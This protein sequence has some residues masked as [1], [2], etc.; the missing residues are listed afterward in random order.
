MASR[1]NECQATQFLHH[2]LLSISPIRSCAHLSSRASPVVTLMRSSEAEC[3]QIADFICSKLRA[4][5]DPS[6]HPTWTSTTRTR[7]MEW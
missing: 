3:K 4:A 2:C 5:K 1:T 7:W 6:M